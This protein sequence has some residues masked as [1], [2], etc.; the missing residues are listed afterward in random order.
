MLHDALRIVSIGLSVLGSLITRDPIDSHISFVNASVFWKL[1][2]LR[3]PDNSIK[4]S[5]VL[6]ALMYVSQTRLSTDDRDR[7]FAVNALYSAVLQSQN[8]CPMGLPDYQKSTRDVFRDATRNLLMVFGDAVL[9]GVGIDGGSSQYPDVSWAVNWTAPKRAGI[10]ITASAAGVDFAKRGSISTLSLHSVPNDPDVLCLQGF[11]VGSVL[12]TTPPNAFKQIS[13]LNDSFPLLLTY[14]LDA[15]RVEHKAEDQ[16]FYQ[17]AGRI[18]F[19][20]AADDIFDTDMA[21]KERIL[22]WIGLQIQAFAK[23]LQEEGRDIFMEQLRTQGWDT[24]GVIASFC[25]GRSLFKMEGNFCGNGPDTV[26]TGDQ[27]VIFKGGLYAHVVRPVKNYSVLIG[28]AYI[29]GLMEGEIFG[30]NVQ[31]QQIRIR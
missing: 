28:Q 5:S 9:S 11:V 24:F 1:F 22:T 16:S 14:A 18:L 8:D 2:D 21:K 31:L 23:C 26:R 10:K 29:P 7:V 17:L 15:A 20:G 30:T 4:C 19:R 12:W 25:E 6:D 3:P 13:S 27:V